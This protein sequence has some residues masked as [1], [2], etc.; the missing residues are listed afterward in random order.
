MATLSAAD[1]WSKLSTHQRQSLVEDCGLAPIAPIR[2]GTEGEILQTLEARPLA[3]WQTLCDALPQR[4][5]K[6]LT[7]A[8]KLL[9][10]KAVWVQLPKATLKTEQEVEAW[11]D[12]ARKAIVNQLKDGPVIV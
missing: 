2:V 11:L 10:P 8:S 3:E 5:A 7:A 9:E 6:A 1:A 12:A 4:F